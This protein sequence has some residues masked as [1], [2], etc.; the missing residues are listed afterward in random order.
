MSDF[1]SCMACRPIWQD[2]RRK[3]DATPDIG[4]D[5]RRRL[6][7]GYMGRVHAIG[8]DEERLLAQLRE[9]H[10][11]QQEQERED[12][13]RAVAFWL[14]VSALVREADRG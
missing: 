3:V 7:N 8:H 11:R 2:F 14:T 5:E 10:E 12:M 9:E 6:I 1:L 4:D 13:R